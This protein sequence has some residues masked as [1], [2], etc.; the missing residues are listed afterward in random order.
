[1]TLFAIPKLDKFGM[2]AFLV[3][4]FIVPVYAVVSCEGTM[5]TSVSR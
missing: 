1:M 2:M 3:M 5:E 4:A